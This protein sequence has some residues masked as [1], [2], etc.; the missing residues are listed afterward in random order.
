MLPTPMLGPVAPPLT[1]LTGG[2]RLP[3]EE[4]E[5]ATWRGP[6]QVFQWRNP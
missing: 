5:Q 2:A 1:E 6:I 3:Y 4:E